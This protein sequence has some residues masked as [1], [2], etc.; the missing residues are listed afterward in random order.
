M[1]IMP[2]AFSQKNDKLNS[3]LKKCIKDYVGRSLI[4][5]LDSNKNT[6]HRCLFDFNKDGLIDV[7][8]SGGISGAFG[9]GAEDWTIYFQ[10][11][12]ANIE[13]CDKAITIE[14]YLMGIN[15]ESNLIFFQ[16]SNDGNAELVEYQFTDYT[17]DVVKINTLE[18]STTSEMW[19]KVD[20]I[21]MNS[22]RLTIEEF[23]YADY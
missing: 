13:R 22:L 7:A 19:A 4:F 5:Q 11:E 3:F 10:K 12:D 8:L 2:A 23:S 6:L 14:L 17:F 1:I 18:K 15:K 9:M 20:S 21:F 16:K